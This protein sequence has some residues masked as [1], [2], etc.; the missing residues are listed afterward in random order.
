M[1]RRPGFSTVTSTRVVVVAAA[2]LALVLGGTGLIAA[3]ASEEVDYVALGDSYTSGPALPDQLPGATGC[4]RSGRNYPHLVAASLGTTVRDVSCSGASTADMTAPQNVP[5]GADAPQLDA[6]G[7]GTDIVTVG[8]GGNDIGFAEIV[9][10]CLSLT[11][12]GRPCQERFVTPDGDEISSRIAAAAPQVGTVL[13]EARRRAPSAQVYAVG[14]PAI[15]PEQGLGCWPLMPFA[16]A[17]VGYLRAKQQELNAM[18][19]GQAAAAGAVYVD[20]YGPSIGHDACALPGRRWVEGV[21]PMAP[22]APLHPNAA[23]MRG[24]AAAVLA[25]IEESGPPRSS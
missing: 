17:D 3:P 1:A 18:I 16:F 14:Y 22:A 11:P 20:A 23:G 4:G 25:A 24:S 15:L 21:V 7:P 10:A 19:A 12:L 9:V 6:L 2:A 8:I 13:A 5:G